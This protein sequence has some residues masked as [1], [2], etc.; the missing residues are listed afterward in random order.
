[1]A[2]AVTISGFEPTL[3]KIVVNGLA[4]DDVIEASG[5]GAGLS[6]TAD[7]GD[8]DDVLIGSNGP[9]VLLG[10]AGD[11]VLIGGPGL[12]ILDGGSGDNIL[13]QGPITLRH[14][15]PSTA[16]AASAGGSHQVS[17]GEAL[18]GSFHL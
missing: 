13:I 18:H 7:G 4:G 5:L 9:D 2:A 3:D 14:P 1:L 15:A 17:I 8:G 12:D 10:S 16:S 6:L 11:D